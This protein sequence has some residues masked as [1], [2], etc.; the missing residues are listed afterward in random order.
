MFSFTNRVPLLLHDQ[1]EAQD[2]PAMIENMCQLVLKSGSP[3]WQ[4]STVCAINRPSALCLIHSHA[5]EVASGEHLWLASAIESLP[6][7]TSPA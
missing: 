1:A 7:R 5:F 4:S 3:P 2:D 6:A